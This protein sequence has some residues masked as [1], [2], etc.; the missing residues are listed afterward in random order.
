MPRQQLESQLR[1]QVPWV[2]HLG[3][4]VEDAQPGRAVLRLPAR[5]GNTNADGAL[6]SGALF[7]IGELAA[8]VAL[9]THPGLQDLT[10][11]QLGSSVR[12]LAAADKDVTAHAEIPRERADHIAAGVEA[13][14]RAT[15]EV[16][17]TLVDGH[18]TDIAEVTA[19]YAFTA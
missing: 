16:R 6:A 12:Y 13:K 3:V 2:R 10:H 17:V 11:L 18:G 19:R 5:E 14:G 15:A 1:E 4:T 9:A 8:T 7:A